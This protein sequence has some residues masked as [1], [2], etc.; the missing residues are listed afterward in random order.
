MYVHKKG[1]II[2]NPEF[3]KLNQLHEAIRDLDKICKS[4][5]DSKLEDVLM[6]VKDIDKSLYDTNLTDII[7]MSIRQAIEKIYAETL[8]RL[9]NQIKVE[10]T[11]VDSFDYSNFTSNSTKECANNGQS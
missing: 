3:A 8:E 10:S 7:I 1:D 9:N 2:M 6:A 11:L 5:S 4:N